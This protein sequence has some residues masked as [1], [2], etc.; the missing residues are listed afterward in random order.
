MAWQAMA[1]LIVV[2]LPSLAEAQAL[3]YATS[4]AG[5]AT[6]VGVVG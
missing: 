4:G 6:L 5:I 1:N 2:H 3:M